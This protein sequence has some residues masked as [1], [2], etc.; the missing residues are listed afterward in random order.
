MTNQVIV[1]AHSQCDHCNSFKQKIAQHERENEET[2]FTV[3]DCDRGFTNPEN[4]VYC[5]TA[6]GYPTMFKGSDGSQC[7]VGDGDIKKVV[8]DCS[9]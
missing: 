9:K 5:K 6:N 3:I 8:D 7:S 2:K 1:A 4:Q